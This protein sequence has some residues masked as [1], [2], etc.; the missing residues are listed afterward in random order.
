LER[1]NIKFRLIPNEEKTGRK[2]TKEIK[3]VSNNIGFL[4]FTA[5]D[6]V[7]DCSC[8]PTVT[9]NVLIPFFTV[10]I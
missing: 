6:N 3:F 4:A 10:R 7:R 2:T 9:M 8:I 5:D 1:S